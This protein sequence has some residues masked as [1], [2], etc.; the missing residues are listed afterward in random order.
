MSSDRT[1]AASGQVGSAPVAFV[2]D[3]ATGAM[4]R[5]FKLAKGARGVDA[6]SISADGK[7]VACVDRHDQHN[8]YVFEVDSGAGRG[9]TPG[10]TNKI[11]DIAF[12]A[13]PGD[14]SFVTVGA[15][16]IK[17]WDANT[18][19]SKRGIFGTNGE[20]TSFSCA[21][22]DDQGFA[23]TGGSNGS[24]YIWS[25]NTLKTTVKASTGFV[26]ALRWLNGKL[27]SGGKDG[28]VNIWATS[29]G[30]LTLEGTIDFGGVLIRAIDVQDGT[31][32]VGL[33]NGTI[34]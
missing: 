5:R 32:L 14:T 27:Y 4:I 2:W 17:F 12:S 24:I 20:Q 3:S 10:D 15:K 28:K 34:F 25:G 9:S 21:A 7:L 13:V 29:G 6:I 8:V 31:M 19:E 30:E 11:F 1:F 23:Y 33:R 18:L 26:G 22:Y 16:H